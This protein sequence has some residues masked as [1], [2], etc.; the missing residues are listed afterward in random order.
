M[1]GGQPAAPPPLRLVLG[2]GGAFVTAGRADLAPAPG[3]AR[4]A[5]GGPGDHLRRGG[6]DVR[7]APA[8]PERRRAGRPGGAGAGG[9]RRTV[10]GRRQH[11]GP[12]G[13]AGP[14]AP[15]RAPVQGGRDRRARGGAAA[16]GLGAAMRCPNCGRRFDVS[17]HHW[18]PA[19]AA[20]GRVP[21]WLWS[22]TRPDNGRSC[23]YVDGGPRPAYALTYTT[24]AA[25]ATLDVT[26]ERDAQDQARMVG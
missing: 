24:S 14:G 11:R 19:R 15:G 20:E 18:Q 12:D 9:G 8:H 22:H 21:G 3:G 25:T 23:P 17:L 7:R 6:G 4:R 13:G 2:A 10:G 5:R 16:R 26:G 1:T